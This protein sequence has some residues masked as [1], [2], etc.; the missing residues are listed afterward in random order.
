MPGLYDQGALLRSGADL[1]PDFADEQRQAEL[2]GLQKR[3]LDLR[4]AEYALQANQQQDEINRRTQY[5]TEVAGL[6]TNPTA[7]GFAGLV[8]KYP[9]YAKPAQDAWAALDERQ[10]SANLRSMGEVFSAASAGKFDLAASA[11]KRRI[12]ADTAAGDVDE[13]DQRLLAELESG[14]PARQRAAVTFI[15]MTI[16]SIAPKE[17]ASAFGAVNKVNEPNLRSVSPGDI[18]YDERTGQKVFESPYR[19]TTQTITDPNTGAVS[20]IQFQPGGGD[21]SSPLPSGIPDLE[22]RSIITSMDAK[23]VR[24]SLGPNG[25]AAFNDWLTRN[26]ITIA[27][28]RDD[29]LRAEAEAA[30]KAGADPAAV[31]AR[32]AK[33]LGGK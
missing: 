24:D 8:A 18:V 11:L 15:G 12:E 19:P 14:D 31:N 13:Q 28:G 29:N 9:E 30:I 33:M 22:G 10:R 16:A 25:A 32:L 26:K 3:Q 7:Q 4:G 2:L 1:I 23:R 6:L 17:F 5:Q 20:V 21:Q 27:R